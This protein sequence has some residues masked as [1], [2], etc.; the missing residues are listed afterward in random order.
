MSA[1]GLLERWNACGYY[2]LVGMRVV[3]ADVDG[4]E[5]T[6]TIADQH[7]QA[8]GTAHGGVLAGLVDA[9]MGLAILG[10]APEGEGCATVEMKLNF[11]APARLGL[12]TGVGRVL[13]DG[14][15]LVVAWGEARDEAD[16]VVACG[17]GTFQ[18]IPA[19]R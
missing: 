14:R 6:L 9:A 19:D 2:N 17:L 12:L 1:S 8:Y 3:R 10:R 5:F 16:R 18:R 11:L 7:L 13:S 4:S 15:R